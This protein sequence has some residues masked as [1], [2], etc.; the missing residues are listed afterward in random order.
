MRNKDY[1]PNV[2]T[3]PEPTGAVTRCRGV[4]PNNNNSKNNH[5]TLAEH[6]QPSTLHKLRQLDLYTNTDTPDVANRLDGEPVAADVAYTMTINE[7]KAS[8][9]N[10][11]IIFERKAIIFL[12]EGH[13]C[14]P[15]IFQRIL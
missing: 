15:Y 11:L 4:R 6:F 9:T 7:F 1:R 5:M 13:L 2:V 8:N 10:M 14:I 12:R 3:R